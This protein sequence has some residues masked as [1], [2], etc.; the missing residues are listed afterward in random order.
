MED[1]RWWMDDGRWKMVVWSR[2]ILENEN[3]VLNIGIE[4]FWN[5]ENFCKRETAFY[6]KS[7]LWNH[8]PYH[9][10]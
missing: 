7:L 4:Y 1:G 3:W 2:E 9:K 8:Y 10:N 5:E 6:K